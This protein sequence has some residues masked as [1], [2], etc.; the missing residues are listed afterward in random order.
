MQD[1]RSSTS[2]VRR[3]ATPSERWREYETE[4]KKGEQK[5]ECD[6]ST[7]FLTLLLKNSRSPGL[8][9]PPFV[10]TSWLFPYASCA[11]TLSPP[12]ALTC[13]TPSPLLVHSRVPASEA[14]E[15]VGADGEAKSKAK[16]IE[17]PADPTHVFVGDLRRQVD[18]DA[19]NEIFS[20]YGPIAN[21]NLARN[22]SFAIVAFETAAA[23]E[24][25]VAADNTVVGETTIRVR[26]EETRMR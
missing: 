12:L 26:P 9:L 25:A 3:S 14:A 21:I 7:L 20:Q 6:Q 17:V 1:T 22:R 15:S 19:L 2:V 24:A 18:E 16:M 13:S 5:D 10:L 23:A 4:S 11:A 8:A